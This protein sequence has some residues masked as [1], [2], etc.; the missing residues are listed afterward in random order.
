MDQGRHCAGYV[1]VS[2]KNFVEAKALP[3][4]SSAQKAEMMALTRALLLTEGKPINIHTDSHYAV[5]VVTVMGQ[6]GKKG[7][8]SLQTI[9]T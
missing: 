5:S 3:P 9:K 8:S 2:L 7:G 1:V 4:E 6:S